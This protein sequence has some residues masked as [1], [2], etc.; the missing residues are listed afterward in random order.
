MLTSC[1]VQLL[2]GKIYYNYNQKYILITSICIFEAGSAICGG[3]PSSPVFIFGRALAGVGSTG[4]FT[5]SIVSITYIVPLK[6]RPLVQ[7]TFSSLFALSSVLS[8]LIG[9]ALTDRVSWRWCFYVNLPFG[10]VTVLLLMLFVRIPRSERPSKTFKQHIWDLDPLGNISLITGLVCLLL[11]LQWGGSKYSWNDGVIIALLLVGA[12]LLLTFVAL[13]IRL[14]ETATV[15]VRIVIRRSIISGI[16]FSF[17]I[18]ASQMIFVYYLPIYF[19]AI[20]NTTATVSGVRTIPFVA[21]VGI[22]AIFSGLM[23]TTFGYYVPAMIIGS[24]SMCIGAG[25]LTT[26]KIDTPEP[27]LIGYQ[28]LLGA[29]L[30]LGQQVAILSTQFVLPKAEVSIGA[31]LILFAAQM[32]G[33]IFVSVA[34]TIFSNRLVSG[35]RLVAGLDPKQVL[36]TGATEIQDAVPAGL[37]HTVL[38]AY[39]AAVART[40]IVATVMAGAA[41]LPSFCMEWLN[42]KKAAAMEADT[43]SSENEMVSKADQK[44]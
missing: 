2:Y 12:L 29:G 23:A 38:L 15:P 11:A 21:A 16:L 34:Q 39:N 9:G 18:S 8:P 19:Q 10:G 26:L 30:G 25:L 4:I 37:R 3:A 14:G 6:Y 40:F 28:I 42:I 13:Q 24:I 5:G 36:H 33:A 32:A 43:Q 31:A 41:I 44:A 7:S 22:A 20:K 1:I 17:C 27:K 35:L